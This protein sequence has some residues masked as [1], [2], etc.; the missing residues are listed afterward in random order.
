MLLKQWDHDANKHLGPIVIT[1]YS[2]RKVW[3]LC[4]QCPDGHLHS[5]ITTVASRSIGGGCPQCSGRSVC[6]HN[7]LATKNPLVAP[8]WHPTSN[9]FSPE[10]V[11]ATS[12]KSAVWQC[13]ACSHVWTARIA[14]RVARGSGC[15]ACSRRIQA[16]PRKRRPTLADSK[17]PLLREWDPSR[18]HVLQKAR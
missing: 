14:D 8:E 9:A 16:R 7:F 10:D 17:S 18:K 2:N 1:P 13:Q 5:W 15:P 3:W 12:H 11:T 6:K 4:D